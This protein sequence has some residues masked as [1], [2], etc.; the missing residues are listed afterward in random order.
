M[1]TNSNETR[2]TATA[3]A[4]SMVATATSANPT[5]VATAAS[6][7][8]ATA[9][10][11]TILTGEII[12]KNLA[13]NSIRNHK[14][15]FGPVSKIIEL[16]ELKE[17][18][19]ELIEHGHSK[20]ASFLGSMASVATGTSAY[21]AGASL[22]TA[23]VFA[24]PEVP[25]LGIAVATSGA[26]LMHESEA[27]AKVAKHYV[28]IL[29]DSTLDKFSNL[30]TSGIRFVQDSYKRFFS[31]PQYAKKQ[32]LDIES[33][34][35]DLGY[36]EHVKN[37]Y[38]NFDAEQRLLYS[39]VVRDMFLEQF[40]F[41]ENM[42][43]KT[44]AERYKN[45]VGK[46][47]EGHDVKKDLTEIQKR[48]K[49]EDKKQTEKL[50]TQNGKLKGCLTELVQD[51]N[52]KAMNKADAGK[53]PRPECN[54]V[55]VAQ[56]FCDTFNAVGQGASIIARLTGNSKIAGKIVHSAAGVTQIVMGIAN[57]AANGWSAGPV[58]MA[59]SGINTLISVFDSDD[60]NGMEVL[61]EQLSIISNQIH[62]LHEDML[63]QFGQVFAA[64]GVIN[65]NIIQGF[66]VLHEDQEKIL[67]NVLLLQ[68]SLFELQ[69]SV[70]VIGQK[71]DNLSSELQG[72]VLE[73]DRK[74]FQLVLNDIRERSR[75]SFNRTKLHT[76]AMSAFK[77]YNEEPVS[78]KLESEKVTS[79]DISKALT[80][81]LGSAEANTGLILNF[82]KNVLNI[83]VKKPIAD[84]EQWRQCADLLIDI[85]NK[86]SFEQ[87]DP[88]VIGEQDY[89]DFKYLK[90]IGDNWLDLIRN[91]SGVQNNDD[92]DGDGDGDPTKLSILFQRYVRNVQTLISL[93]QGEIQKAELET[94]KLIPGYQGDDELKKLQEFKFDYKRNYAYF[95]F[96]ED[97]SGCKG[98]YNPPRYMGYDSFHCE[99][100]AH[101]EVRKKE[102]AAKLQEYAL[103]LG[104]IRS[105]YVDQANMVTF[106]S[107]LTPVLPRAP[108]EAVA[109]APGA[110][111]VPRPMQLRHSSTCFMIS[112]T[113]PEKMPVLPLIR[114]DIPNIFI[115]AEMLGL[116][117]IKYVYR[118]QN[119]E[120][121][122]TI[123]FE[124]K[125]PK[126]QKDRAEALTICKLSY[127]CPNLSHLNDAEAV[128]NA[129][130]GG[131]TLA[132]A[133]YSLEY[134]SYYSPNCDY[135]AKQ[136]CG[137]PN[138]KNQEGLYKVKRAPVAA[139]AG[140][141]P[142]II[143]NARPVAVPVVGLGPVVGPVG[144]VVGPVSW[145]N[146]EVIK[147]KVE[148]KKT[149]L[150]IAMNRKLIQNLE[151][152]D[153]RNPLAAAVF[154]V[155]ASAKILVAFLSILFRENYE[156]PLAVWGFSEILDHL[157]NYQGQDLYISSQLQTNISVLNE[158]ELE[159]VRKFNNQRES[160]FTSVR[161]TLKKLQN[162]MNI[163][164]SHVLEDRE[165]AA[166][167]RA[168]ENKDAAM[169]GATRAALA[170]QS[171]LIQNGHIEAAKH[172]AQVLNR[173]GMGVLTIM[174]KPAVA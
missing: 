168:T 83:P 50:K 46:Q 37:L 118:Y 52:K 127:Q 149:E 89:E 106:F 132:D 25:P 47:I 31:D 130:M 63:M 95:T 147:K 9:V 158:I 97:A 85:T 19:D 126:D 129:Y 120:F 157:K 104:K 69:D 91:F 133:G 128:W 53:V 131:T 100:L 116:G 109:E 44:Q 39:T 144:P 114:H 153:V 11:Q 43:I 113:D 167:E 99:W 138:V 169:Y 160:A 49:D 76:R 141:N 45:F 88:S 82:A 73:D 71:I 122:V 152:Q 68:K 61:A 136:Y 135:W 22:V 16:A 121:K 173:Y 6:S 86:T 84:P 115:E 57:I 103:D 27:A 54:P 117:K 110:P 137:K 146:E 64:L 42:T 174:P 154:E 124:P 162:F 107:P 20:T 80:M 8:T 143:Q 94:K 58:G 108:A 70:N 62:A 165:L 67:T 78:R 87:N 125:D 92:D 74:Q 145:E 32:Y 29:V 75:R 14:K 10:K 159:A 28:P 23:G 7:A 35:F 24:T 66:R 41:N 163:Y 171:E 26:I 105:G 156:R 148:A 33:A 111:A 5:P 36:K 56:E 15:I 150:R 13:A 79:V 166:K 170:L 155:D 12:E 17:G 101:L 48:L 112:E 90:R 139:V 172:I 34:M 65:T 55:K 119:N 98:F 51:A 164:E 3:T 72:Y 161:N 140:S 77:T 18:Y 60:N 96:T 40:Q 38:A 142:A 134:R 59:L 1:S 102:I 4:T 81:K 2:K 21:V 123:L 151:S 30:Y 93:I